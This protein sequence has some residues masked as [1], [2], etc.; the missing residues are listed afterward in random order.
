MKKKH[1]SLWAAMSESAVWQFADSEIVHFADLN[2]G[3]IQS[4]PSAFGVPFSFVCSPTK[5]KFK[6][7]I[8]QTATVERKTRWLTFPQS[9]RG[10]SQSTH[11]PKLWK[12][13][14][15]CCVSQTAQPM[16]QQLASGLLTIASESWTTNVSK[17]PAPMCNSVWLCLP[18]DIDG[19]CHWWPRLFV[20]WQFASLFEG[21]AWVPMLPWLLQT[22]VS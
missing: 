1:R 14:P 8:C 19:H 4:T 22:L 7:T 18:A 5:I 17:H 15:W 13:T 11:A 20:C 21:Q 12:F 10:R 9:Y 6:K 2:S 3:P 16:S